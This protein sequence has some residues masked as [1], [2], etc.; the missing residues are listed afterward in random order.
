MPSPNIVPG[1]LQR[2]RASVIFANF[3]NLSVTSPFLGKRGISVSF[4]GDSTAYIDAMA[5]SVASPE[6]YLRFAM[7]I[8][9]LKTLPLAQQ[10]KTQLELLTLLGPAT[11]RP[12]APAMQPYN[13]SNCSIVSPGDQ[14]FSGSDAD[15][16][17]RVGGIYIINS[18]LFS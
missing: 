9:L 18:S 13:L 10:W 16:P 8:H 17:V 6:P 1:P 4:Q 12:D 14:D 2:L 5:S 3:P 11:L 7:T 15:Y